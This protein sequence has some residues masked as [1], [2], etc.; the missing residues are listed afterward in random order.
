MAPP[1]ITSLTITYTQP[2]NNS[3]NVTVAT[4]NV[5]VAVKLGTDPVVGGDYQALVAMYTT[6]GFWNGL[7]YIPAR[8]ITLIT[9]NQQ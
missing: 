8:Q 9:A 6:R 7:T 2:V 5:N 1:V 3:M 4:V